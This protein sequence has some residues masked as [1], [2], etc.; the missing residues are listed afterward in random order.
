MTEP[1]DL[2]VL[3]HVYPLGCLGADQ[4]G[5]DRSCRRSLREL[6]EWLPHLE[7][8]GA[9][10]LLLGPV[11][12]SLS[13]GYDTVSHREIDSRLGTV[14][15]LDALVAAAAAR[16]VGV[17]LDGAFAYASREFHRL[18]DPDEADDPWFLRDDD[19]ELV[20]WR[21]D[22]LVTPDHGSDGYRAYVADTMAFWLDRGIAGW[23][24]DSAWSVPAAFWRRV[25]G[26]VRESH[27]SAWFLGQVFD[28]D[29]PAVVNSTTV[30]GATEY[31][32]MHG[33]R[34]WLAGGPVDRMVS[35]LRVHRRNADGRTPPHTFLGN[36]DFAR[37]ADAVPAPVL[38]LAFAVLMTLPGRPGIYYGDEVGR[39]SCW[40]AGGPDALLRPPMTL[41]DLAAAPAL[42]G[43]VRLLGRFRRR[44]PWLTSAV[45]GDVD[46]RD[47]V[48]GYTVSVPGRAI[49]VLLNPTTRPAAVPAG[50]PL[51]TVVPTG[52]TELAPLSWQ[53]RS[54]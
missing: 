3:Y 14:D 17:V 43:S 40:T 24:L 26:R 36:H 46:T 35:T 39:T 30:S 34:E 28:D 1:S 29:L 50:E 32:L 51:L 38:P 13:H 31:A 21:V 19:G 47:G 7:S 23:R 16:G 6:V 45:L 8:L 27:P 53:V 5:S 2:T 20:P 4:G 41:G 42:L 10:G 48:L 9:D 25:L 22:S 15:D 52:P 37:L 33:T 49:R 18:T 54:A 44:N 12:A 11:F